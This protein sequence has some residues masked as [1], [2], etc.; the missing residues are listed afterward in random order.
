MNKKDIN[1]NKYL[2]FNHRLIYKYVEDEDVN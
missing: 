1:L 2:T